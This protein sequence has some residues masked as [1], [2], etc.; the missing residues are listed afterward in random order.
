MHSANSSD[1]VKLAAISLNYGTCQALKQ[2][3]LTLR[4]AEVHAM[5]G[6]HGAGK[7]SLG[8]VLSGILKPQAGRLMVEGREYRALTLKS[9]HQCGIEMVQQHALSLN[10]YFSIADNFGLDSTPV[11]RLWR[12]RHTRQAVQAFLTRCAIALDPAALVKEF[13][14]ADQTFIDILKHIYPHPK[15]LILDEALEKLS[16][17]HFARIVSIL[18]ELKRDGM[19]ILLITHRIDDMYDLADRVSVIKNGEILL[20][21]AIRNIDKINLIKMAYMQISGEQQADNLN[22]EFYQFLK[23][24][25]AILRNLPVNLIVTDNHKRIKLV[26]EHCKTNFALNRSSYL[27]VP[28]AHLLSGDHQDTHAL[29]ATVAAGREEQTLYQVP[30][31]LN[32]IPAVTNIKT[33]PIYEGAFLI[34]TIII[35]EDMTEFNQLQK[36][37]MLSEKLASVGLLAAGVAHEIN[38]PL[39]II[40]NYLSYIK[41]NFRGDRLH[42]AVDSVHEEIA[43][44][45][46]IVSNLHSFSDNTPLTSETVNL[47]EVIRN[48]LNLLKHNARYKHIKMH[49]EAHDPGLAVT[50]NKNEIKQVILNL[51]K[52]SFEAMPDGGAI[53]IETAQIEEHGRLFAQLRFQDTGPGICDENPNNIFLPFYSTKQAQANNLGLGLSVSYGIITKYHG[54]IQVENSEGAGCQFVITLPRCA[55]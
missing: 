32:E 26:N 25:E 18:T 4:R 42:E 30:I 15:L 5:V 36:Q 24:N 8:Q 3:N 34:G 44:I 49:F 22:T 45:A 13:N 12:K 52:N 17:P 14:V 53:Y 35:L 23:Y 19:A 47:A 48:M 20:T 33:F 39:E 55:V 2:V 11:Y 10:P 7:S 54:T 31:L 16:A 29:L 9:A 28:L 27:N 51:L 40:Y 37:V 43:S 50:A 21:D 38:N 1:F 6:E 46:A 41:Y